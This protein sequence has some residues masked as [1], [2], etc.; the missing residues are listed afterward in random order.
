MLLL[1]EEQRKHLE[2]V[3]WLIRSDNGRGQ[4]KSFLM[5]IVFLG[6]ALN[7]VTQWVYVF[8]HTPF[9]EG[10]RRYFLRTIETAFHAMELDKAYSLEVKQNPLAIKLVRTSH[11][12]NNN[13]T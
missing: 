13:R 7:R 1:S 6:E 12:D 4:G 5:A 11:D 9:N 10:T 8:D 2:S 3:R